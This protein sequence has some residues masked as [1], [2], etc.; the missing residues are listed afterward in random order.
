MLFHNAFAQQFVA[1]DGGGKVG[2]DQSD[3]II[4]ICVFW[5]ANIERPGLIIVVQKPLLT[6]PV[7]DDI[8]RPP[9]QQSAYQLS[10]LPERFR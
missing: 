2:A 8:P 7:P 3:Q 6:N 9:G 5:A 10:W 1:D 4:E